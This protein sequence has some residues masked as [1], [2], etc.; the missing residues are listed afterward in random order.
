MTAVRAAADGHPQRFA[1]PGDGRPDADMLTA[2][3]RDGYLVLDGFAAPAACDALVVRGAEIIDAF[4]PSAGSGFFSTRGQAHIR[5]DYFTSSAGEVRCFLEEDAVDAD[6]RLTIDK[7]QAANK[8]AHALHD[9]DPVFDRFSRTPELAQLAT[10]LGLAE[11]LLLQSML[12]CKPPRIG[13]EVIC[14]QDGTFLYTEPESVLGFW[15]AL[16]DAG[17]EN[18][19][20]HALRGEHR[21]PLRSRFVRGADGLALRRL[22]AEPWDLAQAVALP[23]RKGDLIVLHGRLPHYS[24]INRS[25]VPRPAYTLHLIDGRCAYAAD[26]WLQRPADMP[27]RGFR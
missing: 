21:G 14:H 10:G 25:S 12:I 7:A 1:A 27:L 6:G 17:V 24:A 3:A 19:C 2:F 18:G 5:D 16:A 22:D 11:P 13:G 26:N 20:L 4:D 23:A 9:R 8:I 15:F